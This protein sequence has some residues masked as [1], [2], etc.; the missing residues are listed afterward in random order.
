MMMKLFEKYIEGNMITEAL[1]VGR[2]LIN[3]NPTNSAVFEKYFDFLCNLAEK[4][5][6][7]SERDDFAGQAG[8][9][10]AFFSENAELDESIVNRIAE[11]QQRLVLINKAI[12]E[13]KQER[14]KKYKSE[15]HTEN[16]NNLK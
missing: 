8:F 10:L 9:A 5:P 14:G 11:Y 7:L 16:N 12:D 1:L 15:I 2:N 4:L 13:T 3:R 6:S